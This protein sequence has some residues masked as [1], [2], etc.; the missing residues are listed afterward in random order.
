[1]QLREKIIKR[2][3]IQSWRR[4]MKE[5]DLILGNFI[6]HSVSSLDEKDFQSYERL[7]LEEDQTLFSWISTRT[8]VPEEFDQ[9]VEK[10]A[11]FTYS[12][13]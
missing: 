9:I 7:L 2:L 5:M 4:G 10:I 8:G 12:K 11:Q 6:D 3:K 13:Y 1:M